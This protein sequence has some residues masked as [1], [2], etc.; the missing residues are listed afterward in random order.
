MRPW[1]LA[2]APS[3]F[4]Q[5]SNDLLVGNFGSGQISAFDTTRGTFEGVLSDAQGNPLVNKGLWGLTFGNGVSAGQ[6]EQPLLL[7]R[8]E[9]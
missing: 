6:H 7:S 9:L 8:H 2:L 3:D 1:G 5:F 4:G